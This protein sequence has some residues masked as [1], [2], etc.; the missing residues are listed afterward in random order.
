MIKFYKSSIETE[1]PSQVMIIAG[2]ATRALKLVMAYWYK[3]GFIG[4]P[5][6]V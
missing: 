4:M 1:T 6:E 5:V 3:R 2:S